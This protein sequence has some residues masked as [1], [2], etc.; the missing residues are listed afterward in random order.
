M[1]EKMAARA[2]V[3]AARIEQRIFLLRGQKVNP[4][5]RLSTRI[6]RLAYH[7]V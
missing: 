5:C 4:H 3:L 1:T 6:P 7:S 2:T